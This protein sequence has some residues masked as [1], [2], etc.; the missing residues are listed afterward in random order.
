VLRGYA[1]MENGRTGIA[2][3]LKDQKAV[4]RIAFG[5]GPV[6]QGFATLDRRNP[7]VRSSG[8][9]QGANAS[10]HHRR[11]KEA[12]RAGRIVQ[13]QERFGTLDGVDR[14]LVICLRV[15]TFPSIGQRSFST[16][17][18]A[19]VPEHIIRVQP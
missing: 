18:P 5:I 10:L 17:C 6:G 16:R 2:T 8:Q 3:F 1:M 9:K 12:Q 15:A 11:C 14:L 13:V 7:G 4:Q 19:K